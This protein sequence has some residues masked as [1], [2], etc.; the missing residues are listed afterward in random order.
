MRNEKGYTI[1]VNRKIS[2]MLLKRYEHSLV[3]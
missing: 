3:Q 2:N 1:V